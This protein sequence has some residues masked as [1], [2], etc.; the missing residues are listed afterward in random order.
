[1][2]P[3]NGV[4]KIGARATEKPVS[5][6]LDVKRLW[7]I[8]RYDQLMLYDATGALVAVTDNGMPE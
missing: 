1:M 3:A 4:Y 5:L 2:L 8:S 7:H 6:Q